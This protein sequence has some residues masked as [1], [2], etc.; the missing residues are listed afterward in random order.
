[1]SVIFGSLIYL[2]IKVVGY[3][4]YAKYLNRLFSKENNIWKV[5][6]VRTLLG[7]VLGVIHNAVLFST[8]NISMGRSPIGGEDTFI[9]LLL[10][11]LLRVFEWGIIVYWF[12]TRSLGINVRTIKGVGLGVIWSFILDIPLWMGLI[13]VIATIC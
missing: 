4:F 6:A 1:M 7:V 5:G 2:V 9:Y 12:Y 8:L 11:I 10:L 3:S 13:A